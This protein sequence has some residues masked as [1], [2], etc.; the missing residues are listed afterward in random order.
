MLYFRGNN[1]DAG[2][3]RVKA[4]VDRVSV[5]NASGLV[6]QTGAI[7]FTEDVSYHVRVVDWLDYIEVHV[8][9]TR[10]LQITSSVG[11]SNTRVGVGCENGTGL[12]AEVSAWPATVTLNSDFGPYTTVP[13]GQGAALTASTF[14]GSDGTALAT[15]DAAWTV[16]A[17]AV[18][19]N[20]NRAF[21]ASGGSVVA[22]TRSTGA[23][24]SNHEVKADITMPS[25]TPVYPIDWFPCVYARYTDIDNLIM[26]RFLYQDT[27][28][29]VEVWQLVANTGTL[30]GYTNLGVGALAPSSTHSLALAVYGAEAAAYLDGMLVVQATT[31]ILTGSRA[32]FG[33]REDNPANLSGT[34]AFDNLEIRAA[35]LITNPTISNIQVGSITSTSAVV[36]CTTDIAAVVRVNYGPTTAYGLATADGASGTSHSR[37]LSGLTPNTTYHYQVRAES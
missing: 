15:H 26:A 5:H 16:H 6:D 3:W 4:E 2:S 27:S 32:G 22:A 29:E 9:G 7:T 10:Y 30:I 1:T 21:I 11:N 25:T 34:P 12:C 18:V 13:E 8:N 28:N 35:Q 20:S 24:A 17:G 37:T 23:A 19:L 36:T 33:R 14:T 31:S